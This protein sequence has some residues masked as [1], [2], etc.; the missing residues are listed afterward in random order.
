MP[1]INNWLNQLVIAHPNDV[2]LIYIGDS[3]EGREML[4]LKLNIG[5]V[6]GKKQVIFEGTM[7]A[8]EWISGAV[9]TWMLNELITFQTY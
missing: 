3:Y 5:K 7:H 2:E 1:E 9:V 6:T 4:G 8:R